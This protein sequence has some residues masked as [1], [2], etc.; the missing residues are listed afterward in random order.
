MNRRQ[1]IKTLGTSALALGLNQTAFSLTE[2]PAIAITIDDFG[3]QNLPE[4]AAL[5]RSGALLKALRSQANLQAAGFI[6]ASRVDNPIGKKVLAQWNQAGHILTNHTYSHWYYPNKTVEEFAAD[7][8]RAETLLKDYSQF[9]KLFRFPYL[10]EGDTL[11]RRD[12]LRVFL[13]AQGYRNGQVTIDTSEWYVDQRLR[14]RLEK[15]PDAKLTPYRE[16][17]LNHIW[18]RATYYNDLSRKVL[19]R[20]VKHTLLIHFNLINEL[21]LGDLLTMFKRKGWKLI[22]AVEAFQDPVFSLE[23]KT[24]PAGESLIWALAK[25]SGKFETLLRYPAED[26][27]YEKPKM[28]KLGL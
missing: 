12:K 6:C 5:K 2:Q 17:Y 16:F 4:A 26:G 22:N 24:L 23:P 28:D 10:K 25:E 27:E 13:K 1:L 8:L 19:G 14:A 11:E 18:D 15:Q 3:L 7:I 9:Q 21:F 20:S